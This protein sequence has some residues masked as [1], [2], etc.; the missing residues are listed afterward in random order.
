MDFGLVAQTNPPASDVIELAQR[1]EDAGFTHF[2]TFDSS[3]A[4]A[5]AL[6]HLLPDPQFDDLDQSR[7]HGHQSH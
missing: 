5:R 3:G 4:V 6:R 1:A 7:A 2:W